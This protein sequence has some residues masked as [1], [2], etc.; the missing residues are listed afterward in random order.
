MSTVSPARSNGCSSYISTKAHSTYIVLRET[1]SYILQKVSNIYR[2]VITKICPCFVSAPSR[3][4]SQPRRVDLSPPQ[5]RRSSSDSSSD[6]EF[7]PD[8]LSNS[9]LDAMAGALAEQPSLAASF[10]DVVSNV[11]SRMTGSF[12]MVGDVNPLEDDD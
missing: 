7:D 11:F 9:E 4:I 1:G 8:N 6:T 2:W 5:R 12:V 10:V 3:E